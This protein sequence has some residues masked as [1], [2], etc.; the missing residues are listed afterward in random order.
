MA[1]YFFMNQFHFGR[2]EPSVARVIDPNV[3][4]DFV[5]D[6]RGEKRKILEAWDRYIAPHRDR[7]GAFPS[8]QNDMEFLPLQ[9]ADLIAWWVGKWAAMGCFR[10]GGPSP[11]GFPWSQ[12]VEVPHVVNKV[13]E[14]SIA[15]YLKSYI[16]LNRCGPV[17]LFDRKK[18]KVVLLGALATG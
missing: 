7:F 12:K 9:A 17:R 11:P 8:F 3:R 18:N 5:F 16:E 10:R 2:H 13:S 15:H 14:L 4:V 1:F 6:D